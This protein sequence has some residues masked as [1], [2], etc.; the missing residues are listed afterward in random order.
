MVSGTGTEVGKTWVAARLATS[1]RA[2]GIPTSARKPVQSFDRADALT[3]AEVLAKASGEA[4]EQVT[5]EHRWYPVAMAPPMAAEVLEMPDIRMQ[6]LVGEISMPEEGAC[7]VEGVGGPRSPL[8]HNG[9]TTSLA[10]ALEADLV[11]IVSPPGLGAINSVMLAVGAFAPLRSIVL[12]N[13]FDPL[14][15]LHV[16]NRKWLQDR[17]ARTVFTEM[18]ELTLLVTQMLAERSSQVG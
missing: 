13:R 16:R 18:D 6:E 11:T 9:D 10:R 4:P 5:P 17:F 3:D 12:L 7:I 15:D 14:D 1:L 2:A 8:A